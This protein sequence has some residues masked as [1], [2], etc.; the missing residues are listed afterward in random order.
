[1]VTN[2]KKF[3]VPDSLLKQ[4]DECS[5]GGYILFNFSANGEPQVFTKFDNQINAMALLYYVNTWSQ[6][7]GK[8]KKTTQTNQNNKLKH[9]TFN[10]YSGII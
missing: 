10:F 3:K 9:L 8:T 5:F 6:S 1:M 7:Q 4:I 2:R